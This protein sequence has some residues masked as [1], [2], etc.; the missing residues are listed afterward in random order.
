MIH[1]RYAIIQQCNISNIRCIVTAAFDKEPRHEI[2]SNVVHANGKG[3][4]Q[5]VHTHRLIRASASRLNVI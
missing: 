2:S 4:D 3:S 5:P 1:I